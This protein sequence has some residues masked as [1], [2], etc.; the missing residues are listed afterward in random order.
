[1]STDLCRQLTP[2]LDSLLDAHATQPLRIALAYSGGLDS[3]V[4]LALLVEWAEQRSVQLFAFHIQHGISPHAETWL[5]H[6]AQIC[7]QKQVRFAS[8]HLQLANW[9]DTGLEEAARVQRYAALGQLCQQHHI[10]LLL[11]AHHLDDQAETVLMHLLRG[12]GVAGLGGMDSINH[13]P[14]LLGAPEIRIARPLLAI[15]REALEAY[16]LEYQVAHIED[17]SNFDPRYTRNALRHQVM[18]HL[19]AN[20][21][22]FQARLARTA[23]HMQAAQ[24][25]L[26]ELAELDLQNCA[27]GAQLSLPAVL[28]LN[29]ERRD[30]LMR[31]WLAL[32]NKRMPSASWLREMWQQLQTQDIESHPCI[33][34]PDCQIRLYRQRIYLTPRYDAQ[35]L[36]AAAQHFV[37]Q[38]EAEIRFDAFHGSLHFVPLAADES[39]EAGLACQY[40]REQKL[41]IHYRRGGEQ[42][43]LGTNRA[44]RS[45]KQHYQSQHI[46]TWQRTFLPLISCQQKLLFAPGLGLD[47]H[48][49]QMHA[50]ESA[51]VRLVWRA[52]A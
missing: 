4:L 40:L 12:A 19:A 32:H 37:W 28:A 11:T 45:L 39:G 51:R 15:T 41:E 6:C 21:P 7:Q 50:A 29:A 23:Q 42:L 20:F 5:Q 52:D 10:T 3:S 36:E 27:D 8:Q 46:P 26:Q 9:Q 38:G 43:K 13:A 44:T 47:C 1:M 25:L 34:H 14:S 48:F 31:H 16:A 35:R 17:E 18:P 24:R 33:S 2:Q 22:Q 30:N 49:T